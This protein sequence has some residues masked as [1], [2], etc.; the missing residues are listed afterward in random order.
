MKVFAADQNRLKMS[1]LRQAFRRFPLSRGVYRQQYAMRHI[2]QARSK[3]ICATN[4]HSR[5]L[6]I[7]PIDPTAP[8]ISGFSHPGARKLSEIVKIQLFNKVSAARASEIW[9]EYHKD[10][11]SAIGD[12]FTSEEYGLLRQRTERCRHFILPVMR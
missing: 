12:V 11:K 2:S 7:K 8:S 3:H 9:S 4:L 1:S 6:S 5:S 10:H